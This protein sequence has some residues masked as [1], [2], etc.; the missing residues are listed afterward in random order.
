MRYSTN[1]V[2][3]VNEFF[4]GLIAEAAEKRF[5]SV[6]QADYEE[7][8]DMAHHLAREE[9]SQS[10]QRGDWEDAWSWCGSFRPRTYVAHYDYV[11]VEEWA[12]KARFKMLRL[13]DEAAEI[14]LEERYAKRCQL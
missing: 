9:G 12:N 4:D 11:R 1:D 5:A 6:T 13:I 7:V 10:P 3:R 14:E 8:R 2:D